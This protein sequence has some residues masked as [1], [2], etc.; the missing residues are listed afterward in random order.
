MLTG[1]I[2]LLMRATLRRWLAKDAPAVARARLARFAALTDPMPKGVAVA[3]GALPFVTVIGAEGAGPATLYLHG[4]GMMVGGLANYGAFLARWAGAAGGPVS[5]VDYR[6]APE[7]P[8][9]AAAEDAWAAYVAVRERPGPLWIAGDS[10][11]GGLALHVAQR[12]AAEGGR[13]AERV[14]LIS[15]WLDL[16]LSGA[17]MAE[18][19]RD[20]AMLSEAA[21]R[22]MA[23]FYLGDA[24][25]R[26]AGASPL[27]GAM[28]GLPPVR[29]VCSA[30]EVLRDD[31][32]RLAARIRE[33]GGEVALREFGGGV[34]HVFP[35]FAM[36]GAGRE[37][38]GFLR[39]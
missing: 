5:F 30:S 29:V 2:N 20:D 38:L 7:H 15:P 1:A 12:A 14:L 10:A 31:S 21:L 27:F 33:A 19:A 6:L 28:A 9:P 39:G 3:P 22:R 34:P 16:T 36:L 24:D 8:Y 23:G 25:A 35:L 13:Q 32:R 4:G 17:S 37:A 26:E 11:G 18:C